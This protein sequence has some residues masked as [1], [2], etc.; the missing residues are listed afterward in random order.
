M[1]MIRDLVALHHH[2]G[3]MI[4]YCSI[5]GVCVWLSAR[6]HLTFHEWIAESDWSAFALWHM[7]FHICYLLYYTFNWIF[8]GS[9]RPFERIK[10]RKGQLEHFMNTLI[11]IIVVCG[12]DIFEGFCWLHWITPFSFFRMSLVVI[13][14]RL[15][16]PPPPTTTTIRHDI[17]AQSENSSH[18]SNEKSRNPIGFS[19][20]PLKPSSVVDLHVNHAD[21]QDISDEA[22]FSSNDPCINRNDFDFHITLHNQASPNEH[23]HTRITPPPPV[24]ATVDHS[25]TQPLIAYLLVLI[26]IV[27]LWSLCGALVFQSLPFASKL[28]VLYEV[29]HQ[30]QSIFDLMILFD[31]SADC[32]LLTMDSCV[33]LCFEL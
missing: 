6:D 19:N 29:R 1:N 31:V 10:A 24:V 16:N 13:S 14:E 8:L 7:Q 28:M 27:F 33:F 17:P 30:F 25:S 20:V 26:V 32:L 23:Q 11:F 2:S 3:M 15:E 12:L 22:V 18:H 5:T 9:L 21:T 4:T